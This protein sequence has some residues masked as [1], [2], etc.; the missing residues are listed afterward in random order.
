MATGSDTN[1]ALDKYMKDQTDSMCLSRRKY[2]G[3]DE[4]GGGREEDEAA[5]FFL[6]FVWKSIY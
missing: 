3:G 4:G 2:V 1:H 6:A 5:I